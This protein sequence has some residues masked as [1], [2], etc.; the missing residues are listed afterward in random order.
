MGNKCTIFNNELDKQ[1][2]DLSITG[3][4]QKQSNSNDNYS[5]HI[6]SIKSFT[7]KDSIIQ[8][9]IDNLQLNIEFPL[10]QDFDLYGY[11]N[12]RATLINSSLK[13]YL[14]RK[15]YK[16]NLKTDLMDFTNELYF[17]YIDSIKN[18][19]IEEILLYKEEKNN[20]KIKKYLFASWSEFYDTDPALEIKQKINAKKRYINNIIFK[21]K[22]KDF[23]SENIT[24]CINNAE[25]CYKGSIE[26]ITNNKCGPGELLYSDGSQKNGLFYDNKFVGW[27]NYIDKYGT[28]YVGLF[29]ND[30]LNGKGLKYIHGNDHI[31]KGDFLNGLRHGFGK[32]YRN[33]MRYEGEFLNDKKCGKG[34]IMFSSGD[35][36]KGE[37]KDNKFNGYGRYKWKNGEEYIGYY[38][39]G[40]FNGEGLHKWGINEY[41]KGEFINGIRQGKGEIG[42]SGGKKII[43]NFNKGKPHGIG[44]YFDEKGNQYNIEFDNGQIISNNN[45][46]INNNKFIDYN[47]VDNNDSNSNDNNIE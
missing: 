10:N 7:I 43:I 42:F 14:L 33:N 35:E 26:L 34:Q 15:K 44:I 24:D 27:N 39:N 37:F 40:K 5:T 32:D 28:I 8:N 29:I 6:E 19:K 18:S 46:S 17:N 4:N 36:Y 25:Y 20:N 2:C 22:N 45:N 47:N 23:H 41:Y 21:Y 31:Y 1:N 30:K 12:S 13:G 16:N 11:I 3:T 9:A 38:L